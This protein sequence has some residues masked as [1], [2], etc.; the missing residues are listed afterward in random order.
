M[1][2]NL[3]DTY[4]ESQMMAYRAARLYVQTAL[5]EMATD[6]K[7]VEIMSFVKRFLKVHGDI[8]VEVH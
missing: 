7:N 2:Y 3:G 1:D 4:D 5:V 8:N 6:T